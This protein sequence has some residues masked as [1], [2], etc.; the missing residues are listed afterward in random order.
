MNPNLMNGQIKKKEKNNKSIYEVEKITDFIRRLRNENNKKILSF[1]Q[2][3]FKKE[4]NNTFNYNKDYN[5]KR[6]R[7]MEDIKNILNEESNEINNE[8]EKNYNKKKSKFKKMVKLTNS[9][10]SIRLISKDLSQDK[11]KKNIIIKH[12]KKFSYDFLNKSRNNNLKLLYSNKNKCPYCGN[13]TYDTFYNNNDK[14]YKLETITSNSVYNK[15]HSNFLTFQNNIFN[16]NNNQNNIP[17]INSYIEKHI[18]TPFKKGYIMPVNQ[19][20]DVITAK[21]N[22]FYGNY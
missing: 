8:E 14:L 11:S 10:S 6:K 12:R 1:T 22:L 7:K 19:I 3:N 2:K 9:A 15:V 13:S 4:K 17:K 18:N 16:V 21:T 20:T 5:E